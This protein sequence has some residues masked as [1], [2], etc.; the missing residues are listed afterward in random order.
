MQDILRV[1]WQVTPLKPPRIWQNCSRCDARTP[2]V[3]SG[4]FRI[5]AQRKRLDA[6]LIYRCA[7]CDQTWNYPV[8]ERGLL[9]NIDPSVFRAL[10]EN[11]GDLARRHAFDLPRL[12][13]YSDQV[14]EFAEV[15][16]EKRL[17]DR[18]V[19]EPGQVVISIASSLPCRIRL[20]RL[21]AGE[22]GLSRSTVQRLHDAAMLVVS[23]GN[24]AAMRQPVRDGQTVAIDLRSLERTPDLVSAILKGAA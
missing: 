11:C 3:C 6:W 9:K 17:R 21:L 16:V 4:R 2:F 22:L 20:D 24:R 7:S 13:R 10:S 19:H 1:L 8:L 12:R 18:C 5:N 23:P 15:T 14:E